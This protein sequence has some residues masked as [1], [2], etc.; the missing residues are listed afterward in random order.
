VKIAQIAPL[1]ESVPP[2]LY[3][4]TERVVSHLTEEL[5]R[6]GHDVTLF[7][8]GDSQTRAELVACVPR[9]LRLDS[10]CVDPL[11]HQVVMMEDVAR[12]AAEFDLL[13]FHVDY[14]HF[15][16]S[17]RSGVPHVTTVHGRID[18]PD[19]VPVYRTFCDMPV[20][21]ISDA[22][23]GPLP[24]LDWQATVQHG[25]PLDRYPF[26]PRHEGYLTFVGRVS[27]EKRLD[28][29]IAIA[30]RSG[31][32]IRIAA[33]VD[34]MDREYHEAVIAPLLRQPG[35]EFLGELGEKDKCALLAGAM[36]LLFPI[37]WPE[38]F[39]MVMIEAMACGTPVVA[40]PRGSVPEVLD[41][42]VTGLLIDGPEAEVAA[43]E[44]AAALD[45]HAVRRRCEERFHVARMT[46][47]Y[48]EV[49]DRLAVA[50]PL[51]ASQAC[52]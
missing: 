11:A 17:A 22:Q 30:L 38:P 14:F 48:L 40:T 34:R 5:V 16:W 33:K 47:E 9:A 23:R 32:P 13:H 51:V 35:V 18:I 15:P 49:Y 12:R 7:A 46:R 1:T 36:A 43:V 19:L 6:Q 37:D 24:W 50:R 52:P 25:L 45:R 31:V 44:K 4:G 39:G 10:R 8:S 42:G 2:R 29:A 27:P 41:E 26:Q 21:S 28:R 20:V 3:G